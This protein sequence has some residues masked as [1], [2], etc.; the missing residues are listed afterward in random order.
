[1]LREGF[2]LNGTHQ[3][4]VYA[5]DFN[6]FGGGVHTAKKNTE[7]LVGAGKEIG[8]EANVDTTKYMAMA[9]DQHAGRNHGMKIDNSSFEVW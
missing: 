2:K 1:L 7:A 3:F 6:I 5:D 4:L 9:R 8:L